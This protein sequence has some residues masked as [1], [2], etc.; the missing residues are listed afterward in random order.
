MT[1]HLT[2]ARACLSRVDQ[3]ATHFSAATWLTATCEQILDHLE[4]QQASQQPATAPPAAQQGDS[5]HGDPGE[6]ERAVAREIWR[7]YVGPS[8]DAFDQDKHAYAYDIEKAVG[9]AQ[10]AIAAA[11][12]HIR[13]KIAAHD[14]EV[15]AQA[16]APIR[17]AL[18]RHPRC[19]IHPDDDPIKCGWKRA[20]ADIQAALDRQEQP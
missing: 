20:V 19:D 2:E 16:L 17:A 15:R 1:D 18:A 14:A 11:E 6:A 9:A 10:D 4:A 7:W 5:G 12:P 13:A 8:T 3:A